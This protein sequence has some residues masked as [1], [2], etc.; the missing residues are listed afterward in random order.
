V[1][2]RATDVPNPEGVLE[3]RSQNLAGRAARW[4][5][6][7]WSLALFGWL[8]FAVAAVVLGSTV[9]H[10]QMKDSEAA[11]GEAARGLELL[12]RAGLVDPARENVL[13]QSRRF[14]VSDPVFVAAVAATTQALA[15]QPGA[16]NI[17][18][19]MFKQGGGGQVSRDGHSVL[20]TF[21]VRGDPNTAKD[22]IAPIL[23]AVAAVTKDRPG[24]A[25][26]EVGDASAN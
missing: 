23:H 5:A 9:G 20:I 8:A 6:R 13:V 19:P 15:G 12:N 25:V 1:E 26:R 10:V 3:M 24:F 16:T 17:E 14:T 18:N 22:R 2:R 7:H 11:S 21:D 4:S